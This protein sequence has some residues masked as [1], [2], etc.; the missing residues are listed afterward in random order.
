MLIYDNV[1][2]SI[3]KFARSESLQYN[4]WFPKG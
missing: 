1:A 4:T 2:L 3:A